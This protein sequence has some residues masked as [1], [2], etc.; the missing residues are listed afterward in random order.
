MLVFIFFVE[1][2][3]VYPEEHQEAAEDQATSTTR[4]RVDPGTV[5]M[6]LPLPMAAPRV[7]SI[8]FVAAAAVAVGFLSGDAL[9]AAQV[10]KTP[11][12]APRTVDGFVG[13]HNAGR[14]RDIRPDQG[15]W[16]V[17]EGSQRMPLLMINGNN[18]ERLVL[19]PHALHIAKLGEQRSCARCHHENMPY[20]K[21]TACGKCHRDMYDTTDIFD[22]A[23][24]ARKL[25][26][27]MGCVL[28]HR[29]D[30]AKSRSTSTP[31]A[32]CHPD[33][34]S[35]GSVVDLPIDALTGYAVSYMDAMHG[36]C[37]T[38]H[39]QMVRDSPDDFGPDFAKCA[40]CHRDFGA[41]QL[42]RTGPYYRAEHG[43]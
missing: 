36:L 3:K 24:H 18:D 10:P 15:A 38:C 16:P 11:V 2:L 20:D 39:Q 8:A 29:D 30:G 12:S 23:S 27:N 31:C 37:V 40:T 7:Y 42:H 14:L 26:G 9:R 35:E 43:K 22:H 17:S 28:C 13:P 32:K 5:R 25:G 4:P 34:I 33:M 41:S 21:N 19:F 1:K 6:L